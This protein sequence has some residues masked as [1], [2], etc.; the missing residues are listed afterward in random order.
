MATAANDWPVGTASPSAE[1][2]PATNFVG[3]LVG[4]GR[5]E[6]LERYGALAARILIAQIFIASGLGK[7]MDW[8]GTEASMASRGMF[9]IPL[10]LLGAIVFELAGGLSLALGYKARL[11]ALLLIVFL[12]PTTLVFHNFW[13]YPP[14]EQKL[15]MI[16]FMK[17][18]SILGGLLMVLTYGPGLLSV[19]ARKR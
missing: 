13:T 3:A 11:G 16:M 12:I 8:S 2:R 15:Q 9:W 19:D 5:I 18:L 6:G 1:Q 10:F 14:E 4:N 17:N 7:I